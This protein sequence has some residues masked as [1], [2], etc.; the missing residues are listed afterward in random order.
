MDGFTRVRNSK[1]S[2]DRGIPKELLEKALDEHWG[3][4]Y[5]KAELENRIAN[6][7][8]VIKC[9]RSSKQKKGLA[10]VALKITIR[11]LKRFTPKWFSNEEVELYFSNGFCPRCKENALKIID[12]IEAAAIK[13]K[14]VGQFIKPKKQGLE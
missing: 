9:K 14:K 6:Y 5:T 12:K 1:S 13:D 11:D 3:D 10:R 8:K 2:L 7:K 4:F